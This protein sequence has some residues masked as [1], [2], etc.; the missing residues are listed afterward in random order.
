MNIILLEAVECQE[1]PVVLIGRR[2]EHIVKILKC[3]KGDWIRAGIIN[4]RMGM[5]EIIDVRRKY[6]F[7]VVVNTHFDTSPPAKNPIDFV[8]ALPRPIMLR[9][10][11][12]QAASLGV[13]TLHIVNANRVEKSFWESSII[14]EGLFREHL[15]QG[16]EQAQDTVV[17]EI[18]LHRRFKVFIEDFLPC[19]ISGYRYRLFAH[20]RSSRGLGTFFTAAEGGRVLAAVGPEGGWVDYE[21]QKFEEHGLHGFSLGPRI[22]KVDTAVINI[23][24]RL[25]AEVERLHETL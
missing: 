1:D 5:A 11:L 2:A 16:L 6:P 20:P 10:I 18:V 22:M 8:L 23:H 14:E 7:Q 25:M 21:I 17:P 4:G 3:E 13:G 9:R 15:L 12:S 19:I 24:G